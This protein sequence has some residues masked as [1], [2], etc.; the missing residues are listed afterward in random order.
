M[1]SSVVGSV[2]TRVSPQRID[3]G[4]KLTGQ[5]GAHDIG[6]MQVRTG[7]ENGLFG[8]DFTVFRGRRRFLT[9]SHFGMLYTRRAVREDSPVNPALETPDLH[10]L[11]FD[12]RMATSRFQDDKNLVLESHFVHTTNPEGTGKSGR[13]GLLIDYPNDLISARF[14]FNEDQ[15]NLDPAVGFIRR[16]GKDWGSRFQFRPRPDNHPW[17]RQFTF[18]ANLS[19]TTDNGNVLQSRE[20]EFT[21]FEVNTHA[22]DSISFEIMP[23]YE[24]LFNDFRMEGGGIV[25]PAGEAYRFT[26]Y[27]VRWRTG[28]SRPV[29][30]RSEWSWGNY[31]SGA[32]RDFTSGVAIR[33]R[34]GLVIDLDGEWNRIELPEGQLFDQRLPRECVEPVQPMDLRFQ[35]PPVRHG[36]P[37]HRL[38]GPFPVDCEAGVTISIS[39]T[40]TTGGTIRREFK[41]LTGRLLP[42]SVIPTVSSRG[43]GHY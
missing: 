36:Q 29:A 18:G 5:I 34:N 21:L 2:S 43:V 4:A 8:E 35:Q 7:E 19:M 33:P 17:I 38:A 40:C 10:T 12:F 25:L 20:V 1:R 9:E 6:V 3:Y 39:F 16:R 32:R 22:N 15:E 14:Q 28:N 11:G 37:A 41:P 27:E 24:F 30:L 23:T 26:R 13:Y 42:S 31:F